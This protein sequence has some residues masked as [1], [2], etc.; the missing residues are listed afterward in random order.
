MIVEQDRVFARLLS[1]GLRLNSDQLDCC[2]REGLLPII[3][4]VEDELKDV[5]RQATHQA[6][7]VETARHRVVSRAISRLSEVGIDVLI[8][9]GT[10]L[11]Y[12]VYQQPWHRSRNDTDLLIR[13]EDLDR[14]VTVLQAEGFDQRFSLP[15]ELVTGELT[16]DYVD[17]FQIVHSLDLHWRLNNNWMLAAAANFEELWQERILLPGFSNEVFGCSY[18]FA[19]LIAS[20]HRIAHLNYAAYRVG[21]FQRMES[22][23]TLWIYDIHL[24]ANKMDDWRDL[25]HIA[26]ERRIAHFLLDGLDRSIALF[27]TSVPA[28]V[29][30]VLESAENQY[31]VSSMVGHFSADFQSF[32]A[33]RGS[34]QKLRYLIEQ[35]FPSP[36]YMRVKYGEGH[37][38]W[39]RYVHRLMGGLGKRLKRSR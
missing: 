11:A 38:M 18:R 6:A 10:A 32:L 30:S 22:D 19:L 26:V 21:D 33:L 28:Q 29:L 4:Q 37:F 20:V 25:C 31:D 2:R 16:F 35:L 39:V 23:F 12:T 9:K 24:L 36:E 27:A 14:A 5:L 13:K 17:R 15:G 7:A 8:I 34:R 1:G 3:D